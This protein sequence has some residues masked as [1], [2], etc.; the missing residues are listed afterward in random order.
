MDCEISVVRHLADDE[1]EKYV[2]T[3]KGETLLDGEIIQVELKLTSKAGQLITAWPLG[4][5]S[6]VKVGPTPQQKLKQ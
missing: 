2:A 4:S 3:L 6:N 5:V 1:K